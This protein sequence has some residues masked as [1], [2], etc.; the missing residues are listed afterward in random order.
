MLNNSV[1]IMKAEMVVEQVLMKHEIEVKVQQVREVM[2]DE[3]GL[4]YRL[5]RKVPIQG[6][7]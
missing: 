1:P 6:N 3:M 4:G 5:T 2:K 7:S